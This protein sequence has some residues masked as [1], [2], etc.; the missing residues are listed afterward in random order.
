M[1]VDTDQ[2]RVIVQAR[3]KI[4]GLLLV[5][6]ALEI[7]TLHAAYDSGTGGKDWPTLIFHFLLFGL[8]AVYATRQIAK[9]DRL[10]IDRN[11]FKQETLL[12]RD[13]WGWGEAARFRT[14]QRG[15]SQL[16][17]FDDLRPGTPRTSMVR[18]GRSRPLAHTWA[19]PAED[20]VGILEAYRSRWAPQA[21]A[22]ASD[23][24]PLSP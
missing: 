2:T 24:K 21:G 9:P 13:A 17:A 23:D 5:C 12:W 8:G 4:V 11:G 22:G 7:L 1:S 15:L 14:Q 19:L 6:L 3:W 18:W 16:V 10:V 20:I